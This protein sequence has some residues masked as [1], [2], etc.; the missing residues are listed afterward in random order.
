MKKKSALARCDLFD[1]V[2]QLSAVTEVGDK[3][4][5][6]L[7][8]E[9]PIQ[10]HNVRVIQGIEDCLFR[11]YVWEHV[12]LGDLLLV[13]LSDMRREHTLWVVKGYVGLEKVK[14]NLRER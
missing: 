5:A 11:Q 1:V 14:N 8:F 2:E 12:G 13:H 9:G 6:H 4:A 3:V 7:V 10:S